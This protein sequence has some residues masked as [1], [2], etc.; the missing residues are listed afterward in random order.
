MGLYK[1]SKVSESIGIMKSIP[2]SVS[3]RQIKDT[4]NDTFLNDINKHKVILTQKWT[5]V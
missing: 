3:A 5:I 4:F 1:V 2:V